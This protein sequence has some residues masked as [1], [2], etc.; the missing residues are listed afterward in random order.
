LSLFEAFEFGMWFKSRLNRR[1]GTVRQA[2]LSAGVAARHIGR[3]PLPLSWPSP[4]AWRHPADHP[5]PPR[6]GLKRPSS[7]LCPPFSPFPWSH[8]RAR[9]PP[10]HVHHR[11][12]EDSDPHGI[13]PEPRHRPPSSVSASP[14]LR[15][16]QS[17]VPSLPLVPLEL[18]D[19]TALVDDYRS[20]PTAIERRRLT[21]LA[22]PHRR[23]TFL[24]CSC[25]SS[26]PGATSGSHWC[27][28]VA[29]CHR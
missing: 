23:P 22:P 27:L 28:P 19:L 5:P 3:D 15:S 29:P 13:S 6:A 4:A 1:P 20:Y 24:V 25:P 9:H 18:H 2:R 21:P 17:T 7:P 26:L 16:S 11:R 14:S 8:E 12:P 10:P